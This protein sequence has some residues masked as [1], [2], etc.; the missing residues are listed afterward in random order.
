MRACTL[1][2]TQI[3]PPVPLPPLPVPNEVWIQ[4]RPLLNGRKNAG[5]RENLKRDGGRGA[6][7]G[8]GR[9]GGGERREMGT[10]REGEGE[11]ERSRGVRRK[12]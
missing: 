9:Q 4:A 3:P 5:V 1:A 12:S 8:K 10:E 7:W 2:S 6:H 11:K